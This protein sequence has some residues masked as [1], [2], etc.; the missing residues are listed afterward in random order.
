MRFRA[1]LGG[2]LVAVLVAA[3]GGTDNTGGGVNPGGETPGGETPGGETPAGETPGNPDKPGCARGAYA[4]S[5]P[6]N[7]SLPPFNNSNAWILSALQ[8]RYPL[9]KAIVE[10]GVNSKL[11][12]SQ[13]NCI[14]RFLPPQQRT[15]AGNVLRNLPTVVHECGHFYDLG[16][17]T[18]G[19]SAYVV[20]DDLKFS[21]K[22]GDT[23]S[24]GG[25]TFARS[26]LKTD[27]Y[28]AARQACA[29]S[30]PQAGCDFYANIYL[31][32]S[33]SNTSFEGGD[34]GYNSV[35][36]EATQYVNS[37]A[38]ALAFQEQYTGTASSQRDG[39]LTFLW[40]IER[41]LALAK[42]KY[43]AAYQ[44]ITGDACW[45]QATLSVWD[46]GRFYLKATKDKNNLRGPREH[47]R[48][49]RRDR[50][51]SRARMQ[52]TR[53]RPVRLAFSPDSDDIFMFWALLNGK[54]DTGG[55]TFE[56]SR[57]DTETLN[58]RAERGDADVIAVSIAQYARVADDYLLLPHGM[59]VGRGYGPV[60]VARE[61]RSLASLAGKRIGVPGTRTTSF[62]VLS[63]LLH[64]F[65]PVVVPIAPYARAFEELRG[66][67]IDAALLIHEG[68]LFYEREGTH[69]VVDLG[70]AWA[71]A[72]GGLPLPLGG[73]AIR[74][75]L[76]DDL[77]ARISRACRE[78]IRWALAN[79]DEVAR[80][81]LA[82]ETRADV[83]LDRASLDR[84]LS[85]YANADTLDAPA[86]VRRAIDELFTRARA[87]RLVPESARLGF[88]P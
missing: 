38:T 20:R 84:Y 60:V 7:A 43:P 14:D 11:T 22:Q 66:E 48:A 88:A 87:A 15:S 70:E 86:D 21:C 50:G 3:C 34:Q 74:R 36:E 8:A 46:R 41:Y 32:G 53:G 10:G 73:N 29:G 78:S 61:T 59:S 27:T 9:G 26:L 52:V 81:L 23:T 68:R 31:D 4:E 85:M 67:R 44:A 28:Y 75:G 37:L 72:T 76:D 63:L 56:A 1:L 71:E 58:E 55:L 45:R 69:K 13:G 6:T 54:I 83:G 49:R 33:P 82:A 18:G 19:T 40:Y 64:D 42:E 35:L 12:Q 65:V 30:Q 25:K 39:I 47:A 24:R 51:A 62:L 57:A 2:A 5:L 16:E 80:A 77:V 79:A 17:G